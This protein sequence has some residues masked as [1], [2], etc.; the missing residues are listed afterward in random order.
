MASGWPTPAI[1]SATC[2]AETADSY[3]TVTAAPPVKSM[4]GFSR[5]VTSDATESTTSTAEIAKNHLRKRTTRIS[6]SP[7]R[8]GRASA[9][10]RG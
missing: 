3:A 5:Y 1:A 2:S 6:P 4:P 7:Q 9:C 8:R 10:P